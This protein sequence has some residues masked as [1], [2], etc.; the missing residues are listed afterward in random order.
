MPPE[1]RIRDHWATS[2]GPGVS[3]RFVKDRK[4]TTTQP[5][6][7]TDNKEKA[8]EGESVWISLP[9]PLEYNID[10]HH[11]VYA[12][13]T[14]EAAETAKAGVVEQTS[15]P[16]PTSPPVPTASSSRT[17]KNPPAAAAAN[18]TSPLATA[19]STAAMATPTTRSTVRTPTTF[20]PRA[21]PPQTTTSPPGASSANNNED[22]VKSTSHVFEESIARPASEALHSFFYPPVRERSTPQRR[23]PTAA[24]HAPLRQDEGDDPTASNKKG[25]HKRRRKR[26]N[27]SASSASAQ[28]QP[29]NNPHSPRGEF[30]DHFAQ[31]QLADKAFVERFWT[32][33]DDIIILSLFT[34]VGIVARLGVSTWFTFFDGL[35]LDGI[36]GEWSIVD[37]NYCDTQR[38]GREPRDLWGDGKTQQ[39]H[40]H[41]FG[42][43]SLSSFPIAKNRFSPPR[44]Q[45][46]LHK[47]QLEA[48]RNKHKG[49]DDGTD[50]D[51]NHKDYAASDGSED[52]PIRDM[53]ILSDDDGASSDDG[54]GRLDG[55]SPTSSSRWNPLRSRRRRRR[56]RRSKWNRSEQ[57]DG[58]WWEPPVRLDEELRDVQLL[59]LERRIRQ[60]KCLLLFPLKKEDVDVMEHYFD[61]GYSKDNQNDGFDEVE[62]LE[63][64]G[65]EGDEVKEEDEDVDR[66]EIRRVVDA[67]LALENDLALRRA[68]LADGWDVGTTPEAMSDD[69]MLGLRLGFCG[70]L[71]SFSS[72]N[73][74]MINLIRAGHIGEAITGYMLGIQ[75]PIVAYRF[76]QHVAVFIF[77]WRCRQETKRDERRGYGIR[78]AMNE[79]SERDDAV[80]GANNGRE[81]SERETPSVRAVAT[82]LFVMALVTQ[83]TSIYFYND[84]ES[85]VVALSLLFSPLGVIARWR[86]TYYNNWRPT[87]PIGTFCCNILACGLSGGLGNLIEGNPGEAK[88]I[89]LVSFINGFG[90]TLSSVAAFIIEI[91]AG[92][93]PVLL[94]FDGAVYAL[95]SIFWALVVGFVFTASADWADETG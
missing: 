90:G 44:L 34:Q 30:D 84:A 89:L 2:R 63:N 33:F 77:I 27:R 72:W 37:G 58:F 51:S 28:S 83:S 59:A 35:L 21:Q 69:L 50:D 78:V 12:N 74:A 9:Q 53:Q 79:T 54:V 43:I 64:D 17:V 24:A 42:S 29:S 71:S 11:Y 65:M 18:T 57:P 95:L 75:L 40:V 7:S 56:K 68:N 66:R 67:R 19:S 82:A 49:H 60:S 80:V 62:D 8:K 31:Q 92:I 45:Q 10:K 94:R 81:S 61:E 15:N 76:G 6:A 36:V 16:Q 88:R 1:T 86:L 48:R 85:Q 20:T 87:F 47:Q 13:M 25:K 46:A 41:H 26:T 5:K 23:A 4:T 22:W 73:S 38:R 14:S 39:Q 91:L 32:A 55:I 70:A 93:D 3:L 52:L